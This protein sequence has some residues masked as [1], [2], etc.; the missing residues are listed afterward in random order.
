MMHTPFL[1]TRA[2]A[3]GKTILKR[4][5][6]E[7]MLELSPGEILVMLQDKDPLYKKLI[8]SYSI[9]F[10]SYQLVD[11]ISRHAPPQEV[12]EFYQMLK[13][14]KANKTIRGVF[15][16]LWIRFLTN[17]IR[18]YFIGEI[19]KMNFEE[20]IPW[21]HNIKPLTVEVM[22]YYYDRSLPYQML[23][24]AKLPRT[25]I[26]N[27]IKASKQRKL[28]EISFILYKYYLNLLK[29][30]PSEITDILKKIEFRSL[31]IKAQQLGLEEE[32]VLD[33]IK[34]VNGNAI[35]EIKQKDMLSRDC[36]LLHTEAKDF[37]YYYKR[38]I[39]SIDAVIAYLL[40]KELQAMNIRIVL[41]HEALGLSKDEVMQRLTV[42]R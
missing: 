16:A 20:I 38:K 30:Y 17:N 22:R 4:K 33:L 34:D 29:N 27:I 25:V 13:F 14:I 23:K 40:I 18:I 32:K 11:F 1:Y 36:C 5:D 6:Y 42:I 24:K 39:N 9:Y 3:R 31:F 35:K 2:K 7:K 15:K 28:G 8:K 21:L 41:K 19:E 10:S 37:L 26:E 12:G